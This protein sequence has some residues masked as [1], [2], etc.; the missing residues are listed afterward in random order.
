[1]FITMTEKFKTAS[2][3]TWSDSP[4]CFTK[5]SNICRILPSPVIMFMFVYIGPQERNTKRVLINFFLW[6][7]NPL[8]FEKKRFRN[9]MRI[10][11]LL[12]GVLK[13]KMLIFY[14]LSSFLELFSFS[15]QFLTVGHD[16]VQVSYSMICVVVDVEEKQ[17]ELLLL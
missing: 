3:V 4:P 6:D 10:S 13:M 2:S 9:V 8:D 14:F 12:D 5:K 7:R 15:C 11:S 1:M 17:V 16:A